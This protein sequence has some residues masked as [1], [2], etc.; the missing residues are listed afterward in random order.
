MNQAFRRWRLK[1]GLSIGIIAAFIAL[2]A[3]FIAYYSYIQFFRQ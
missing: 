1:K 2:N 3:A